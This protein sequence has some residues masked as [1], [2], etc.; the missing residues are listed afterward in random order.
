LLLTSVD[1]EQTLEYLNWMCGWQTDP[2]V[3]RAYLD[4]LDEI[5]LSRASWVSR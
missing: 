3:L 2:E 1:D 5:P 4:G